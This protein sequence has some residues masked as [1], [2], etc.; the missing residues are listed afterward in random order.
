MANARDIK[1]RIK[2]IGNTK[3]ITRA[4]EMVAAAKMRQAVEA[5]LKTRPYA[6]LSWATILN[7]ART[8]KGQGGQESHP[9]L[10]LNPLTVVNYFAFYLIVDLEIG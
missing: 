4:M 6:N 1:K 9:L 5:M 3:K 10:A 8:V 2:S 7:L